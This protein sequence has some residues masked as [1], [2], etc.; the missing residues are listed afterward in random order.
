MTAY[1]DCTECETSVPWY[2]AWSFRGLPHD[3]AMHPFCARDR[4]DEEGCGATILAAII[5][6]E[7]SLETS[8]E[9]LQQ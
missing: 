5:A 8:N 6:Y 4:I 3:D 9:G 7:H 2:Y 1:V